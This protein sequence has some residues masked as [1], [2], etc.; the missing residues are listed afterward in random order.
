M[1]TTHSLLKPCSKGKSIHK[2]RNEKN[3]LKKH[4]LTELTRWPNSAK[5]KKLE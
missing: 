3:H 5:V 1:E 4:L 2:K